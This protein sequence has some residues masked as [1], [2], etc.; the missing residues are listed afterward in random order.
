M[1]WK[2]FKKFFEKK[3]EGMISKERREEL[4]LAAITKALKG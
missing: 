1:R 4:E 2:I 3:L